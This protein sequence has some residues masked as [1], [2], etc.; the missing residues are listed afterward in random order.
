MNSGKDAL[1]W[2]DEKGHPDVIVCDV[3]MPG[4]TGFEVLKELRTKPEAA[5]I[6]FLFLSSRN[7]L[8]DLRRGMELGADDY[9]MKPIDPQSLKTAIETRLNKK[10]NLEK[11]SNQKLDELRG[12]LV[13]SMPHELRTPISIILGFAE[14][15]TEQTTN[16]DA[17]ELQT[18]GQ[19]IHTA[20]KRLH[21][22][23]ENYLFYAQIE[24]A[25]SDSVKRTLL[26]SEVCDTAG[27]VLKN[28]AL[29]KSLEAQRRQDLVTKIDEAAVNVSREHLSVIFDEVIDNAFKFSNPGSKVQVT[30]RVLESEYLVEVI[31]AGRGMHV[32]EIEKIGAFM[33]FE[34]G[35]H[36]QQGN[37][38]GLSIAKRLTEL[39]QGRFS[40]ESDAENH[41]TKILIALNL[42]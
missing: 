6:P 42:A 15:L 30:T 31:D 19:G 35:V 7:E 34:R 26:R 27:L 9:L 20:A 37:G 41:Y 16:L 32:E 38:L 2:I 18:V 25:A 8:T 3:M 1:Q 28:C 24:I 4:M 11:F 36:E 29:T 21:H 10:S 14:L 13:Y 5:L 17:N 12:H 40:V 39:Y 33:Q 23:I 22:S